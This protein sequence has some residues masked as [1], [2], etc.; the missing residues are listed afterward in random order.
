MSSRFLNLHSPSSTL[1]TLQLW[2]PLSSRQT[3]PNLTCRSMHNHE[4]RPLSRNHSSD[5]TLSSPP[6]IANSTRRSVKV[7]SSFNFPLISPSDQWGNWTALFS[8]GA[9]GSW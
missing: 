7:R 9:I 1:P 4:L 6:V 8:I 2:S 5:A 3:K